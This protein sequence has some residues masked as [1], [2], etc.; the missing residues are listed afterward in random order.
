MNVCFCLYSVALVHTDEHTRT[1]RPGRTIEHCTQHTHTHISHVSY[2]CF[3][4]MNCDHMPL[5]CRR[6]RVSYLYLCW[7]YTQIYHEHCTYIYIYISLISR[8]RRN[9]WCSLICL[10][11]SELVAE[12]KG[13][14]QQQ[15]YIHALL[16]HSSSNTHAYR[17]S[18]IISLTKFVYT[19]KT[20]IKSHPRAPRPLPRERIRISEN[21]NTVDLWTNLVLNGSLVRSVVTTCHGSKDL[22]TAFW[23]FVRA[24]TCVRVFDCQLFWFN[25]FF[26]FLAIVCAIVHIHLLRLN[27]VVH[28]RLFF[29]LLFIKLKFSG[30]RCTFVIYLFGVCMCTNT[31]IEHLFAEY[32]QVSA[33]WQLFWIDFDYNKISRWNCGDSLIHREITDEQAATDRRLIRMGVFNNINMNMDLG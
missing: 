9:E 4:C 32:P 15:I 24:V 33:V 28:Y 27:Q 8:Q 23:E 2:T 11:E 16:L 6:L 25:C 13:G 17:H 10:T 31:W 21:S 7:V 29:F 30:G 5:P 26:F 22:H 12:T 1:R 14:Q 3:L 19:K 18:L 20:I